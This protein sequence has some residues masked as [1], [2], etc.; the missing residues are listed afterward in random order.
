MRTTRCLIRGLCFLLISSTLFNLAA[1]S[2]GIAQEEQSKLES[3]VQQAIR[4][5]SEK[6]YEEAIS[7][8]DQLTKAHPDRAVP[9]LWLG[10]AQFELGNLKAAR[11]AFVRYSELAPTD[12]DGPLGVART[13]RKAG[14]FGDSIAAYKKAAQVDPYNEV[15]KRELQEA[16]R[17]LNAGQTTGLSSGTPDNRQGFWQNGIAGLC[18]ARSVWWG[19]L[20]AI[21]LY[22]LGLIQ[23]AAINSTQAKSSAQQAGNPSLAPTIALFAS[24]IG[25][26]ISY[27]VFWGVPV[28]IGG[29][30]IMGVNWLIMATISAVAAAS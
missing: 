21:V 22:S 17:V 29:W 27:I 26:P 1:L 15:V 20:I 6:K 2:P 19:R 16:E 30:I 5:S 12:V 11:D 4:F 23:S 24:V 7:I 3:L 8:L 28:D 25:V 10:R 14:N 13:Q 9:F 18:G